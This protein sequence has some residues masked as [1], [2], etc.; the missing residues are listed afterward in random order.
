M[1]EKIHFSIFSQAEEPTYVWFQRARDRF[2]GP[3][4]AIFTKIGI[5]ADH[6][7][8]FNL[9]LAIFFSYFFIGFPYLSLIILAL[10][11]LFDSLDG[12][13]ARFQ[14]SS[15]QG[16]AL[17]DIVADH[18]FLF[19]VIFTLIATK[20]VDG[21]WGGVYAFN[22]LLM[23]ILVLAMRSLKL[24]VFPIVRSKYYLYLLW[25]LFLFTGLNYLDVFFVFFTVYM[26]F[27]NLLLF[28]SLRCSLQ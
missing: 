25:I 2:F 12:C 11:V 18:C 26:F 21:F 15:S 13:L 9:F 10:S 5:K 4:C 22:Y 27:T 17:L 16:G 1:D 7:T 20:S 24:H 23:V 3:V 14:K 19:V 28:N 6:M 8:Y